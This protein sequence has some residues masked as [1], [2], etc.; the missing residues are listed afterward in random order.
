M[1]MVS[2]M[3]CVH[4]AAERGFQVGNILKILQNMFD[5]SKWDTDYFDLFIVWRSGVNQAEHQAS[6][7]NMAVVHYANNS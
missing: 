3:K 5:T 4:P 1:V 2:Q 6:S 7:R